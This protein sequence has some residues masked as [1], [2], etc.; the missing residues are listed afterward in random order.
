MIYI[1]GATEEERRMGRLCNTQSIMMLI[2]KTTYKKN[3]LFIS[4]ETG[5]NEKKIRV[6]VQRNKQRLQ[7]DNH[8]AIVFTQD[9]YLWG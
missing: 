3:Y 2:R 8:Q 4:G 6:M 5:P 1:R 7:T 9:S